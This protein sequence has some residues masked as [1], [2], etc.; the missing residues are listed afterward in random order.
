MLF[1][2]QGFGLL[3]INQDKN[4]PKGSE[5]GKRTIP[6]F[7]YYLKQGEGVSGLVV[8]NIRKSTIK[9]Y[10]LKGR[11]SYFWFITKIRDITELCVT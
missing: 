10:T 7:Y 2:K 11:G 1:K 6:Y 9:F 8:M 3:D 5:I 4:S